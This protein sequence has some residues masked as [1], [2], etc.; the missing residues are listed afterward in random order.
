MADETSGGTLG[1]FGQIATRLS[2]GPLG[3]VALFLVLVY[4]IAALVFATKTLP[5]AQNWVLV[6]FITVFPV[7]VFFTLAW[8]VAKHHHK[9]YPP[10]DYSKDESFLNTIE[11]RLTIQN[12]QIV[13][14]ETTLHVVQ[15]SLQEERKFNMYQ[16]A[17]FHGQLA[18]TPNC[19]PTE[20]FSGINSLREILQGNSKDRSATILLARIYRHEGAN[21][22]DISIETLSRFL[23]LKE[24]AKE[25]D[26]D[27]ADVLY[28]RACYYTVK[29]EYI[30]TSA[31]T[32]EKLVPVDELKRRA[33]E[34][35]KRS[36][37]L[38]KENRIDARLDGDFEA[39]RQDPEF[40]G[41]VGN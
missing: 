1:R 37:E 33:I 14:H 28:N 5:D 7:L 25:Y 4:G 27:Y 6:I 17:I 41:L 18:L 19:V 15:Q 20:R 34:D 24:E 32:G 2:R 30:R 8:L 21:E 11:R 13:A 38:S 40:R 35:L 36:I 31:Y 29:S 16:E 12:D 3:I 22:L 9:L 39:I 23:G 10:T 26:K